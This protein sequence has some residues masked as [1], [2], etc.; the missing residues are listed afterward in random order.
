ML[1]IYLTSPL[2]YDIIIMS[3]Y[4]VSVTDGKCGL[5]LGSRNNNKRISSAVRLGTLVPQESVCLFA[6][7]DDFFGGTST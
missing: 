6:F 4:A 7:F 3:K 2:L 5:P 1:V